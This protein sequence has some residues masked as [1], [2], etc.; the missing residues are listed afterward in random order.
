LGSLANIFDP[1]LMIIGGSFAQ[2]GSAI[3]E[4]AEREIHKRLFGDEFRAVQ[5][6]PCAFG[7]NASAIG[8]AG[9]IWHQLLQN[10]EELPVL[11]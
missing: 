8:A 4:P 2:L 9:Y 3:F 6:E 5:L 11:F 10:A 7:A 1:K